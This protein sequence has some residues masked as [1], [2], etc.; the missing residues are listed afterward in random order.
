MY[1]SHHDPKHCFEETRDGTLEVRVRGDSLPRDVFGRLYIVFA[2]LRQ[3]TLVL[4]IL[5]NEKETYDVIFV[6]QLSACV[7]ILKWFCPA[8]VPKIDICK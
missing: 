4:W 6:D 2:I 5:R 8:K 3:L 1:T 7:P